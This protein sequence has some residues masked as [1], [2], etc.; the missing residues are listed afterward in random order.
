MDCP[1][2]EVSS[3]VLDALKIMAGLQVENT[4]VMNYHFARPDSKRPNHLE[5]TEVYGNETAFLTIQPTAISK[6]PGRKASIL[7]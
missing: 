3:T 6:L 4:G 1:S 7:A 5:F 2:D